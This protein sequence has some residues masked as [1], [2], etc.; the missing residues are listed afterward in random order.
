MLKRNVTALYNQTVLLRNAL[1]HTDTAYIALHKNLTSTS[2]MLKSL[3]STLAELNRGLYSLN[4]TYGKTYIGVIT[5]HRAILASGAYGRGNLTQTEAEEIATQTG[6]T[7]E[8]VYAVFNSV[9]PVYANAGS[10]AITDTFLA[11]VTEGIIKAGS[12]SA[13]VPLVE[14]YGKAFYLEVEAFDQ[15]AGSEYALQ[16]M[17]SGELTKAVSGIATSVLHKLPEAVLQT[18]QTIVVNGFGRLDA[19]AFSGIVETAISL[20]PSPSARPLRTPPLR[21]RSPSSATLLTIPFQS[22]RT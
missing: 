2:G 22:S 17:S 7:P 6:T 14:A 3:N 19:K 20:G 9:Y 10:G 5:V 11:N 8:F 16:G 13:Q 15:K 18:N 12:P 4:S 1:N 21:L